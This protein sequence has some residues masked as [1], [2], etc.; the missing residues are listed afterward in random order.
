MRI[1]ISQ[2]A[3]RHKMPYKPFKQTKELQTLHEIKKKANKQ[4][5]KQTNK[6]NKRA[7]EEYKQ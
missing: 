4:T 3:D 7:N 2:F 5:N 6:T 1:K